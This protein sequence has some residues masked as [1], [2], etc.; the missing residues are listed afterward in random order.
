[1]GRRGEEVTVPEPV[2]VPRAT[3]TRRVM[4]TNER[5]RAPTLSLYARFCLPK[6]TEAAAAAIAK[7]VGA[8]SFASVY[9]N[10]S[11]NSRLPQDS[12]NY[13]CSLGQIIL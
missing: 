13:F 11:Q 5:T 12:L 3:R 1:M 6:F 7:I 10:G 9:A 2:C 8:V 4:T